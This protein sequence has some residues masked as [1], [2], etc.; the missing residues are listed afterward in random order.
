M[1][2][3]TAMDGPVTRW[4]LRYPAKEP[5]L[6]CEHDEE[7]T[8]TT[9]RA[10]NKHELVDKVI[11]HRKYKEILPTNPNIVLKEIEQQIC[12]KL[13]GDPA[14]CLVDRNG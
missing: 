8:D 7:R 11:D 14:Y 6:G 2:L 3:V 12:E 5:P 1:S 4:R 10:K 9:I 13:K